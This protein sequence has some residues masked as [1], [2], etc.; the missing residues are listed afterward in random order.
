MAAVVGG[1]S[2]LCSLEWWD[3]KILL[4]SRTVKTM[5]LSL[6]KHGAT[7]N[8]VI[9]KCPLL[10]SARSLVNRVFKYDELVNN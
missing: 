6:T 3:A 2:R 9:Y 1:R 5:Q 4:V 10:G 7:G 8:F